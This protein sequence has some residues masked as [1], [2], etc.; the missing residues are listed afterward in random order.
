MRYYLVLFLFISTFSWSQVQLLTPE[1]M[2][3]VILQQEIEL[4]DVR[5]VE[6]FNEAHIE[7]AQ[8]LVFDEEFEDKIQNLDTTKTI[9]VYCQTANRSKLCSEILQEKGFNKILEL[10][11][12]LDQWI[13]EGK[14]IKEQ[15][16]KSDSND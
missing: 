10:K 15:E 5:T 11:G 6:E 7:G 13:L 3:A 8:N 16:N 1:E 2:Q 12:G 9:V 4:I 14:P